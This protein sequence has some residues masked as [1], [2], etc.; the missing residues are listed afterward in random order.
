MVSVDLDTA[1]ELLQN[2]T[3]LRNISSHLLHG[4]GIDDTSLRTETKE[5]VASVEANTNHQIVQLFNVV[6]TI[7]G[8]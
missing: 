7:P 5:F 2:F 1:T 4:L 8:K 3:E 6:G